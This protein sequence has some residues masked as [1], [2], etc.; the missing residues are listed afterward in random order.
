LIQA[1]GVHAYSEMRDVIGEGTTGPRMGTRVWPGAS[2]LIFTVIPEDKK[3]ELAAALREKSKGFYP[4]EGLRI[5][6]LP[7]EEMF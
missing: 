5:F 2:A 4:S 6:V 7:V 3:D 1:H